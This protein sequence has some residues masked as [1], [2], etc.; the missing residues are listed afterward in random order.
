MRAGAS[1]DEWNIGEEEHD[2][3]PGIKGRRVIADREEESKRE[4]HS[5]E[6]G[7]SSPQ[8]YDQA[9]TDSDLAKGDEHSEDGGVFPEVANQRTNW[10]A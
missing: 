10:A 3:G 5:A 9:R 1:D 7:N 8:T 2:V 4:G 6:G